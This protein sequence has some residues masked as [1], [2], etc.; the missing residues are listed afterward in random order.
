MGLAGETSGKLTLSKVQ[1]FALNTAAER[2]TS[3]EA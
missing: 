2:G 1:F 3:D